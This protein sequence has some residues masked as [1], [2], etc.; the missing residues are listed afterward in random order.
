VS[1]PAGTW[2]QRWTNVYMCAPIVDWSTLNF[3]GRHTKTYSLW[4]AE[5]ADMLSEGS[6]TSRQE[7]P[8]GRGSSCYY[9]TFE[10][11]FF[12]TCIMFLR[13][14]EVVCLCDVR[15]F[16]QLVPC[17]RDFK[18]KDVERSCAYCAASRRP[19][20]Q[21]V[22]GHAMVYLVNFHEWPRASR[23]SEWTLIVMR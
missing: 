4:L 21:L 15:L 3:Q 19:V 20:M 6:T 5:Q 13:R 10:R 7:H 12:C 14:L 23:W 8:D 9:W 1:N 11:T 2:W 17:P 22:T 18:D 16:I